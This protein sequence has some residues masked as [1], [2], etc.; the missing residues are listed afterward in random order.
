ME[1]FILKYDQRVTIKDKKKL[2]N[3]VV[4]VGDRWLIPHGQGLS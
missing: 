1:K 4:E 3:V 2:I